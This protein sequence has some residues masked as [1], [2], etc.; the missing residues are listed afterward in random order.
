MTQ[1]V[2]QPQRGFDRDLFERRIRDLAAE[3][4]RLDIIEAGCGRRWSLRLDDVDYRLTGIDT[5]EAAL[6]A[7]REQANDLDEWIVG[8]LRTTEL[9]KETRDVVYC[10]F[11]LEHVEGARQALDRFT[12]ALRPGGYLILRIPDRDSVYGFL[13][14]VTPFRV[15]VL[16]RRWVT[17]YK[18]A[19]KPGH[20]PY[21]TA[22][23]PEISRRGIQKYCDEHGLKIVDEYGSDF[24]LS[25]MGRWRLLIGPMVKLVGL[26]S[27]GRLSPRHNNLSFV[28]QKT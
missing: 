8:D 16:Y 10:A 15:H 1:I 17:G 3:R 4:G 25:E 18:D 23:D 12:E 27:F 14:R 26:L 7:R 21:P 6:R 28:I 13:T 22:Y 9:G 11:V 2:L 19:G 5:D 20:E 24:Y